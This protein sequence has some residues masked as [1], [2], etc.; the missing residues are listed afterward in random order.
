VA[1]DCQPGVGQCIAVW[2]RTRPEYLNTGVWTQADVFPRIRQRS[3]M[4]RGGEAG[5]GTP[6][7][8]MPGSPAID[9]GNH[10][11]AT[12]PSSHDPLLESTTPPSSRSSSSACAPPAPSPARSATWGRGSRA[13]G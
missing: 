11:S 7:A 8:S 5:T 9:A 13:S 10:A 2:I 3:R 1:G 6:R 12:T 4:T